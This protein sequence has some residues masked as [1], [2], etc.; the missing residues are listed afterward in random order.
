MKTSDKHDWAQLLFTREK[1]TQ[2][3]V[4][5]RVGVSERTMSTWVNSEKWE[6]IRKSIIV[7]KEEQLRRIYM[8][9]DE[10]NTYIME[11]PHGYRFADS[12]Q[13][14]ALN[15]LTSAVRKL[16]TEASIADIIEVSKRIITWVR[17]TNF[18]KAKELSS[19][20]DAFIKDQLK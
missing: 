18:E 14:D 1:L 5:R 10:L 20:I 17:Q 4:A 11:K 2:K 6:S 12:K 7:T 9:I 16:E 8:Q 3:E 15:K 19:L 13:A